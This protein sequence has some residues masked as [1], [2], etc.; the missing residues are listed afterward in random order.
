MIVKQSCDCHVTHRC[1]FVWRLSEDLTQ[2]RHSRCVCVCVVRLLSPQ[3]MH[4][5]LTE[6]GA[7]PPPTNQLTPIRAPHTSVRRETYSVSKK[8]GTPTREEMDSSGGT[9]TELTL[10]L[11]HTHTHTHTHTGDLQ[12]RLSVS[13][14]PGW[15]QRQVQA[16][17][18][19]AQSFSTSSLERAG[20]EGGREGGVAVDGCWAEVSWS[21]YSLEHCVCVYIYISSV[22]FRGWPEILV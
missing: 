20:V 12:F 13:Q 17:P 14:L 16:R 9:S 11:M 2:V 19:I 5:R 21:L 18:S 3:T 7:P 15:A 8:E 22:C 4:D 1:I 6:I 10:S